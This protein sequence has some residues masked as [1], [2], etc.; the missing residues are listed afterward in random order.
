M[1]S[2]DCTGDPPVPRWRHSATVVTHAGEGKGRSGTVS[3]FLF[4]F[5]LT[6]YISFDLHQTGKDFLFVFGGRNDSQAVLDDAS[7]LCLDQQHWT[8]V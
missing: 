8:E 5:F 7:F 2:I 6:H 1:K 4:S 3:F